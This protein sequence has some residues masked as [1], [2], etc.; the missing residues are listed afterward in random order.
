MTKVKKRIL[1]CS[2]A[3][4]LN[5]GFSG[6]SRHVIN[7]LYNSGKYEIAEY[8]SYVTE[9]DPRMKRFPWK[10]YST[11]PEKSSE[12]FQKYANDVHGQFGKTL[13]EYVLLDFKPDIL[14]DIRDQWMCFSKD[15]P[16]L[17]SDGKF[18]NIQLVKEGD[19]VITITGEAKKVIRTGNR[20]H[21]QDFIK[22]KTLKMGFETEMTS[23]HPVLYMS[24][25]Q[26]YLNPKENWVPANEIKKTGKVF[27]PIPEFKDKVSEHSDE[28]LYSLGFFVAEGCYLKHKDKKDGI[29]ISCNSKE[30]KLVEDKVLPSFLEL[31]KNLVIHKCRVDGKYGEGRT[32]RIGSKIIASQLLEWFG[33]YA[34]GK[35]IPEWIMDL[36][37]DQLCKFLQ[38][39]INGDGCSN[40]DT[41]RGRYYTVSEQLARQ[42]WI[43]LIKLGIECSI[44]QSKTKI[45]E[46]TY[47]RFIISIAKADFDKWHELFCE[48]T[49][50][51]LSKSRRF[52]NN[53]LAMTVRWIKKYKAEKIVY[54]LEVEDNNTFVTNFIVHNCSSFQL[55]S[56][57]RKYFKYICMPTIDG[58]PQKPEWISDYRETDILLTYTEYGK[59]L[60][61]K[62]APDI[63]VFD[64]VRP[65]VDPTVFKPLNRKQE[66]KEKLGI[67]R[68]SKVILSVM[69]NQKRKLYPDLMDSFKLLLDK[70]NK[71][72]VKYK[73]D[74][75]LHIHTSYPDVGFDLSSHILRNKISH[76]VLCTYVCRNCSN[77]YVSRF[78]GEISRCKHCGNLSAHMPNTNHGVTQDQLCEVYN[79]ADLYVQ[80]SICEGLSM[81]IAEA[82]ACGIP[83]MAVDYSAMSE[84][85]NNVYGCWP[86]KVQRIFYESVIETE[87]M[88]V[89]PDNEDLCDKAYDFLK[90][91]PQEIADM[92]E[93]VFRD[94]RDN[95]SLQRSAN[96]FEKA[97]DSIDIIDRNNTWD[98]SVPNII[99]P[100][101]QIPDMNYDSNHLFVDWCIDNIIKQPSLKNSY[102]KQNTLK[103]LNCG[104]INN[105][106]G[107]RGSFTKNDCVDMFMSM[108]ENNNGWENYK[109]KKE[110][111][112]EILE[113]V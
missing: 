87:Q 96:I 5:T 94:A 99:I 107:Q 29:Q 13:L 78:E 2:E 18:K 65:A 16:V 34:D 74:V 81:P 71:N 40:S 48:G 76:R 61:A 20:I 79:C 47:D 75:Y 19:S 104:Y 14:I 35:Y 102:F 97:I 11:I 67:P 86:I 33:E 113:I 93:S 22:I 36:P 63:K 68:D 56:P 57:F 64:I 90:I 82:K 69:R 7:H 55:K 12:L 45:E 24:Q 31:D 111:K 42:T 80:Y 95:Y 41:K 50:S 109:C 100:P 53:H 89:L 38:G 49:V 8:A 10:Y 58:E 39:L 1:F 84:Q 30:L 72:H 3:S 110:D 91:K 105:A 27:F 85:V 28:L 44:S 54:N 26:W 60:L 43:L 6:I 52:I 62:Q 106:G 32:R 66:L 77:F 21:N 51:R 9:N 108:V 92:S 88:R 70:L 23:E 101:K 103:S 112:K 37:K 73:D 46:K 98:K 17:M 4:C 25:H 59:K 83:A 15:T